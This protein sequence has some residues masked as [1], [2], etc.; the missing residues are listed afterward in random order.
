MPTRPP[1]A[2]LRCQ[3]LDERIARLVGL[4]RDIHNSAPLGDLCHPAD[5]CGM[6]AAWR[7]HPETCLTQRTVAALA[8]EGA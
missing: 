4:L 2:C 3:S 7:T 5:G 6:D 8:E 1:S